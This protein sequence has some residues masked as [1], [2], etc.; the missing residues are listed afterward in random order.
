MRNI[1]F[2]IALFSIAACS[3]KIDSNN[4]Q[5]VTFD[6]SIHCENCVSTMFDSL[7]KEDGVID[8]EVG[9]EEKTVTVTFNADVVKVEQLAEKINEL[10]YS[11]YVKNLSIL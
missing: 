2:L 7:P 1:I 10:G 8:L 3:S 5:V 11:A 4:I 6:T 9:L